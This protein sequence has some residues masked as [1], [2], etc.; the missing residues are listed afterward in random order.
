MERVPMPKRIVMA[1]KQNR[2]RCIDF[3]GESLVDAWVTL[4]E[5]NLILTR[6]KTTVFERDS[7]P[8]EAVL[9]ML[10]NALSD[11]TS[12]IYNLE[13]GWTR[14]AVITMR[15]AVETLAVA[16]TIHHDPDKMA[17][18]VDHK[19]PND[20]FYQPKARNDAEKYLPGIKGLYEH[21]SNE[22]SHETYATTPRLLDKETSEISLVPAL[23]E[24]NV[25]MNLN[26]L[27]FVVTIAYWIGLAGEICFPGIGEEI[28][29][30]TRDGDRMRQQTS[31]A[32]KATY[33]IRKTLNFD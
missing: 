9:L 10:F 23:H 8:S 19:F 5:A 6:L 1:A 15:G 28:H 22:W 29:W 18:F 11:L 26:Q 16:V 17:R 12:A 25:G 31:L 14:P 30:I 33:S 13:S 2:E 4:E 27:L 21:L 32:A 20:T 24:S 7:E 3:W